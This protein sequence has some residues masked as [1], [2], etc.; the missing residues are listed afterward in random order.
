M[1]RMK[2]RAKDPDRPIPPWMITFSD[3]VT[4]LMT[5]FVVLV[6][7]ASLT[8]EY[9]RKVALGSVSGIFGTGAQSL[10]DLTTLDLRRKVDPGPIN[11]FKDLTPVKIRLREKPDQDLR[12]ES[13]RFFQRLS[14]GVDALFAPGSSELTA[15]GRELLYQIL[16]VIMDSSYPMI[17]AGHAGEGLEEFG[18][19]YQPKLG[20][21]VDFSWSLSLARVQSVYRYFVDAGISADKLRSEAF[22][23]IRRGG[24]AGG[25]EGGTFNGRVEITLDRRIGSWGHEIAEATALPANGEKS[26]NSISV[27]DFLFRF[28]LPGGE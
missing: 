24:R 20:S 18:P 7:M 9:K 3:L 28:D 11:E 2:E 21:K 1:V 23:S 13:N 19:E 15:R 22:G 5:F 14:M 6:S 17:L 8:D 12:F 4:L 27:K 25:K 16:P 26:K 10:D